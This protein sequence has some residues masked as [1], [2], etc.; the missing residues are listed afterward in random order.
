MRS[1]VL[2]FLSVAAANVLVHG[3]QAP[4]QSDGPASGLA[5]TLSDHS[6]NGMVSRDGFLKK[7]SLQVSSQRADQS[8]MKMMLSDISNGQ[9]SAWLSHQGYDEVLLQKVYWVL[10]AGAV[11]GFLSLFGELFPS[12]RCSSWLQNVWVLALMQAAFQCVMHSTIHFGQIVMP[13]GSGPFFLA[14]GLMIFALGLGIAKCGSGND[15][16]PELWPDGFREQMLLVLGGLANSSGA[17]MFIAAL[18]YAPSPIVNIMF[19]QRTVLSAL[20]GCIF[21]GQMLKWPQGLCMALGV[22]AAAFLMYTTTSPTAL[23]KALNEDSLDLTLGAGLALGG[24]LLQAASMVILRSLAGRVNHLAY[25]V[26]CGVTSVFMCI[27]LILMWLPD[28]RRIVISPS[29]PA[30]MMVLGQGLASALAQLLWNKV[31]VLAKLGPV[32]TFILGAVLVL[33]CL[34][35]L[36]MGYRYGFLMWIAF[37]LVL[38]WLPLTAAVDVFV[39]S[40]DAKSSSESK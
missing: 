31:I 25:M 39:A 26:S 18:M 20:G 32:Q 2:C 9:M 4:L 1:D 28:F 35:D 11:L 8:T 21:L 6:D 37:G 7:A 29:A 15:T 17:L 36:Y 38:V 30:V 40:K 22:A 12:W 23:E 5:I 16:T 27:P 13:I 10:G 14:R 33:Q 19:S 34:V 24:A 3:S